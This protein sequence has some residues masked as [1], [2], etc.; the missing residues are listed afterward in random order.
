MT[1]PC[2]RRAKGFTLIELLVVLGILG[3]LSGLIVSAVQRAREAANRATC[4]NNLKQIGLAFHHADN[5]YGCLPAG[6]GRY[7]PNSSQC[8]GNGFYHVL[9]FLDQGNLY[10]ASN[11]NG[12]YFA[13]YNNVFTRPVKSVLCPS[14]PTTGPNGVVADNAGQLWGACSYAGNAQV[15]CTVNAQGD[16]IG[17]EN[18]ARLGTSFVNGTSNT[19]L[20]AEKSAR[21]TN[22]YYPEGGTF[23]AY[24]VTGPNVQTLHPAF[25]VSWAPWS[26]GPES[27]FQVRPTPYQGNCDPSRASTPHEVMQVTLADGSVRSLPPDISGETW[28]KACDAMN[29]SVLGPDW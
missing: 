15:F 13:G 22:N 12:F 21:C 4:Q 8:Y 3:T 19:L 18:Y 14:D 28:W 23:W 27:R 20:V 26:I 5:T 24:W 11:V 10:N 9:P 7:P 17:T 2:P 1:A 29:P 6:I 25:A 16:L